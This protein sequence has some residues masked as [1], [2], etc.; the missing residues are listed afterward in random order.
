MSA[1]PDVETVTVQILGREYQVACPR[2]ERAALE[3]SAR[4][5]DGHM[6]EIQSSG[7]V[8]GLERI[9]VMAALNLAND[10]LTARE[11]RAALAADTS[12][13]VAALA[14]RIEGAIADHKQL[15]L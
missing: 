4:Y 15:E 5:L 7:K 12:R 14:R 11:D 9:A 6:R 1:S 3:A 13:Q 2:E 8:L 10:L